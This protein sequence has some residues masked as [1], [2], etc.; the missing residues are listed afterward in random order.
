MDFPVTGSAVHRACWYTYHP[1][2]REISDTSTLVTGA[3][4]PSCGSGLTFY[5]PLIGKAIRF[6]YDILQGW[7][8][9]LIRCDF[10]GNLVVLSL[11]LLNLH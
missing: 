6:Q 8:I 9:S 1:L 2:M 7:C 11:Y 5:L 3:V 10:C 4:D